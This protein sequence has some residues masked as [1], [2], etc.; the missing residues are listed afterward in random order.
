MRNSGGD[1][2]R[3]IWALSAAIMVMAAAQTIR[4]E[5]N[6]DVGLTIREESLRRFFLA[7]G[8]YYRVPQREVMI[9]K[10]RGVPSDEVPVVLF[11][12]K[13]AHVAPENI[14][15]FRLSGRTWLE[16]T[17]RF[18]LSPEIFYVPVG[19]IVTGPPYGRAF[20]YYRK[21]PKKEW[22]TIA[23]SDDDVI[24]LVNLKFMSE[25]Y[26]CPPE[27]IIRMRSGG[28]EFVSINE[29]IGKEDRDPVQSSQ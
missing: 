17:L 1:V 25:H 27:K 29:E 13:R 7:V 8:D 4:L 11:L 19:V 22:K 12:A 16:I 28:K 14:M 2:L 21:R 15:D 24:N 5:A 20:G 26:K 10:E 3:S 6:G 18:G 9:I 23:I